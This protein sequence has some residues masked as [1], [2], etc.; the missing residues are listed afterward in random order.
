MLGDNKQTLTPAC[1]ERIENEANFAAGQLLFLQQ[2]F[3]RDARD[4]NAGLHAIKTLKTRYGNTITTTLWRYVEQSDEPMI[5]G[6]SHHPCRLPEDF[7]PVNPFRYFV[8]SRIFQQRFSR[9]QE[10][11]IFT[12]IRSYCSNRKGGPLGADDILLRDDLGTPHVFHFETFYNQYEALTLGVY[13]QQHSLI[14]AT[15]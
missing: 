15:A 6:I 10:S 9:I 12:Q 14:V 4:L 11:E 5:G 1:H 2:A 7:D 13:R 8:G 3:I